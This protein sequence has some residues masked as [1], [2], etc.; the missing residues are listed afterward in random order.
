[1]RLSGLDCYAPAAL[2]QT[3]TKELSPNLFFQADLSLST[4][5]PYSRSGMTK[6]KKS[7]R[8]AYKDR[9]ASIENRLLIRRC[10]LLMNNPL[11]VKLPS[12]ALSDASDQKANILLAIGSELGYLARVVPTGSGAGR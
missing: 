8:K 6:H 9:L 2:G 1:M 10:K 5:I 4:A 11:N 3:D 12:S 7:L